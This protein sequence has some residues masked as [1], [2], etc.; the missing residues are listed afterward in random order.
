L[1][2]WL[3]RQPIAPALP[4]KRTRGRPPEHDW[5]KIASIARALASEG[6]KSQNLFFTELI[7]TIEEQGM[8]APGLTTLK[9]HDAIKQIAATAKQNSRK[10]AD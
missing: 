6:F 10:K 8:N 1:F 3:E 9:T 2:E 4:G 5:D 7:G